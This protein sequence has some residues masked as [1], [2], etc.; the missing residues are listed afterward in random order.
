M[1]PIIKRVDI[2]HKCDADLRG[3]LGEVLHWSDESGSPFPF[4]QPVCLVALCI[5]PRTS[6]TKYIKGNQHIITI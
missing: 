5:T 1:G 6:L 4:S 3:K 2:R